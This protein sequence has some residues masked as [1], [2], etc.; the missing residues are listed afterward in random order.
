VIN[1]QGIHDEVPRT[2]CKLRH[3]RPSMSWALPPA[4]LPEHVSLW[5]H[6][7]APVRRLG[8]WS[9]CMNP[10]RITSPWQSVQNLR[11]NPANLP[12]DAR[13]TRA[14]LAQPTTPRCDKQRP[15]SLK[16]CCCFLRGSS[17]KPPIVRPCIKPRSSSSIAN[18]S[19]LPVRSQP[20]PQTGL[21]QKNRPTKAVFYCLRFTP[22]PSPSSTNTSRLPNGS[23]TLISREPQGISSTPGLAKR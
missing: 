22:Q 23:W 1:T 5:M 2:S 13:R 10:A 19:V 9:S 8:L 15:I 20:Q 21:A 18:T 7:S 12:H 14:I 6:V 11:A 16:G 3:T 17:E 4:H